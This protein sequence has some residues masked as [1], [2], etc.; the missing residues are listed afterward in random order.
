MDMLS[1]KM[2]DAHETVELNEKLCT[3]IQRNL[4]ALGDILSS[5]GNNTE[6]CMY[7]AL[8]NL[9]KALEEV[10]NLSKNCQEKP[11]VSH[12]LAADQMNKKLQDAN[13]NT[14]NTRTIAGFGM[15]LDQ[16][17]PSMVILTPSPV[18]ATKGE[19]KKENGKCE[20]KETDGEKR[21]GNKDVEEKTDLQRKKEI[22]KGKKHKD[23]QNDIEKWGE[24]EDVNKKIDDERIKKENVKGKKKKQT[25]PENMEGKTDGPGLLRPKDSSSAILTSSPDTATNDKREGENRKCERKE[26][27]QE[28]RRGKKVLKEKTDVERKKEVKKEKKHTQNDTEK[29]TEN[30]EA[31]EKI[32]DGRKKENGKGE[33][34]NETQDNV[35]EKR[36]NPGLVRPNHASDE[37]SYD[38]S[39]KE[40]KGAYHSCSLSCSDIQLEAMIKDLSEKDK[41]QQD[42]DS[43]SYKAFQVELRDGARAIAHR[44]GRGEA[45]ALAENEIRVRG[46]ANI[47]H[48]HILKLLGYAYHGGFLYMVEDYSIESLQ[49]RIYDPSE[50]KE[51]SWKQCSKIILCIADGVV[52]LHEHG[53]I[54]MS[55]H[56]EA[57]KI[58]PKC[59][60]KI[61]SFFISETLTSSVQEGVATSSEKMERRFAPPEYKSHSIFSVKT[62]VYSYGVLLLELIAVEMYDESS[63]NCK[64][65]PKWVL[66]HALDNNLVKCIPPRFAKGPHVED[67]KRCIRIALCCVAEDPAERPTMGDVAG[68]LRNKNQAVPW[69]YKLTP[70]ILSQNV[71]WTHLLRP[72]TTMPTDPEGSGAPRQRRG[73][74]AAGPT[75]G[76]TE[77]MTVQGGSTVRKS[78]KHQVSRDSV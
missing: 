10:L 13:Q 9:E 45:I 73:E 25:T 26:A 28:K 33:K 41:L 75:R 50:G 39:R 47:E 57:I 30:E 36:D 66:Q 48:N 29:R 35:K 55:L 15:K 19:G 43:I 77:P 32:D 20:R 62:D 56:P 70:K 54:H 64:S 22:E 3:N 52:Y 16:S 58:V 23:T 40:E 31:D 74:Q 21:R 1:G 44:L 65:L 6:V 67:I 4:G 53:V 51:L 2:K 49:A 17:P 12:H 5:A 7:R 34:K 11:T 76:M 38:S 18:T 24:N 8:Q 60:A 78:S 59:V 68:W 72:R 69:I 42:S 71:T 63:A 61:S 14:M 27:D 37:D 46:T